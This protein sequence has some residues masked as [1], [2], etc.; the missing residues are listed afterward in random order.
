MVRTR[1]FASLTLVS[2]AFI[3]CE[4]VYAGMIRVRQ[5]GDVHTVT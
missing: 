5:F 4:D 1:G 3:G 2:F